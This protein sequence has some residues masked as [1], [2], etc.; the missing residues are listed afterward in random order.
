MVL[1]EG[2]AGAAEVGRAEGPGRTGLEWRPEPCREHAAM[3][4]SANALPRI[5]G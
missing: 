5:L 3:S 4:S 2:L 1:N